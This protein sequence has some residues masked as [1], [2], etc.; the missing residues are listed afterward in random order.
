MSC[1]EFSLILWCQK[2][3][4]ILNDMTK[5]AIKCDNIVPY[6]GIFMR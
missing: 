5:V 1:A 4:K 2:R 3:S 6:G